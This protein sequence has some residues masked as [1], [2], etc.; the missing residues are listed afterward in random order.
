[1]A[2]VSRYMVFGY[3]A[4]SFFATSVAVDVFPAA[5]GPSIVTMNVL[6]MA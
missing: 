4:F 6:S 3:W 1:M 2:P 5:Q